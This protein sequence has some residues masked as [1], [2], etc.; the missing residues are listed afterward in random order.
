MVFDE[1][2]D[3]NRDWIVIFQKVMP[4]EGYVKVSKK[5]T[6]KSDLWLSAIILS[7]VLVIQLC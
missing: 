4:L 7:S 2:I 5:V 6:S 1:Q 3:R